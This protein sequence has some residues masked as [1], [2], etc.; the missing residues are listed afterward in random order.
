ME[1]RIVIPD[2]MLKAA[3]DAVTFDASSNGIYLAIEGALRWLSENPI[4]PTRQNLE[5]MRTDWEDTPEQNAEKVVLFLIYE[6]QRRM[7]LAPEPEVP[8]AVADLR[9]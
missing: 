5:D 9:K 2:G 3:E 8:E 6:W 1:S 4:V 7:F